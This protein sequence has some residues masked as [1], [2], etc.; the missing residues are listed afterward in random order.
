MGCARGQSETSEISA[1]PA[2]EAST[3]LPAHHT[4]E[5]IGFGHFIVA[6]FGRP[7][8]EKLPGREL[9]LRKGIINST[10]FSTVSG[11]GI[12]R[13]RYDGERNKEDGKKERF[14]GRK[15]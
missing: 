2:V 3:P 8:L 10:I 15:I 7:A 11:K 13:K 5:R 9:L 4:T 12:N 6:P 14:H 1:H